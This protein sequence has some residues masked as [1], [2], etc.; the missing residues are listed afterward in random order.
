MAKTK[1]LTGGLGLGHRRGG[2]AGGD[3]T[4]DQRHPARRHRGFV[5]V[6]YDVS[7]SGIDLFFSGIHF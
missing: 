3:G 2:H 5:G 1:E 4:G 7:I 6:N